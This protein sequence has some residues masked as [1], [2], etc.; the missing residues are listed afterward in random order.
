MSQHKLKK[1]MMAVQDVQQWEKLEQIAG[2]V[3]NAEGISRME[4]FFVANDLV[5]AR[6]YLYRAVDC[7]L[8]QEV[9]IDAAA[10]TLYQRLQ[11]TKERA[12]VLHQVCDDHFSQ[13]KT[14]AVWGNAKF[15]RKALRRQIH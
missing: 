15:R 14:S 9:L 1:Q 10:T 2:V 5:G 11:V 3:C 4:A 6:E 12:A 13:V 7:C 8:N